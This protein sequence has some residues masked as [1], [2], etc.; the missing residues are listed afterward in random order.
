MI[1]DNIDKKLRYKIKGITLNNAE[2]I[3]VDISLDSLPIS[4]V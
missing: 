3:K 1:N 2:I 4:C